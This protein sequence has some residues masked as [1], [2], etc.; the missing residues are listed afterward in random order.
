MFNGINNVYEIYIPTTIT[1]K[2]EWLQT[3]DKQSKILLSEINKYRVDTDNDER[4][5]K[6]MEELQQ[7][8]EKVREILQQPLTK[9]AYN[10]YGHI[11]YLLLKF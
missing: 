2:L 3:C 8:E 4:R 9:S 7:V 1:T 11:L 10:A 6:Q 5:M